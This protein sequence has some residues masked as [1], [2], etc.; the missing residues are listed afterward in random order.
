VVRS[1]AFL[2]NARKFK[3][4]NKLRAI[5]FTY[6]QEESLGL[7]G[8]T[9]LSFRM[10]QEQIDSDKKAFEDRVTNQRQWIC[11]NGVC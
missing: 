9:A 10:T 2:N 7:S 11:G 8:V 3:N 1:R 6:N 4:R 5:V